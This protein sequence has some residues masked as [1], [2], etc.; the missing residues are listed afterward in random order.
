MGRGMGEPSGSCR[1]AGSAF[2]WE[3]GAP[4]ADAGAN[5]DSGTD[6]PLDARP[7]GDCDP[8]P[9]PP[10]PLSL[11]H[12]SVGGRAMEEQGGE[13]L[14]MPDL[15]LLLLLTGPLRLLGTSAAAAAVG[16]VDSSRQMPSG[17]AG[18]ARVQPTLTKQALFC[19]KAPLRASHT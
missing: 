5:W 14:S 1:G 18:C 15:K 4:L 10:P 3:P 17:N 9:P 7:S 8:P 13:P 11:G 2:M 16:R 12:N 19:L 6:S